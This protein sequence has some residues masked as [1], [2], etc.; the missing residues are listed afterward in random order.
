MEWHRRDLAPEAKSIVVRWAA[1]HGAAPLNRTVLS[2]GTDAGEVYFDTTV[3]GAGLYDIY[4]LPFVTN[5]AAY[6]RKDAYLPMDRGPPAPVRRCNATAAAAA[7]AAV[8]VVSFEAQS[9]FDLFTRM[10]VAASAPELA[11]MHAALLPSG[12]P[13]ALFPTARDDVIRSSPALPASSSFARARVYYRLQ[14]STRRRPALP[15][16]W[17]LMISAV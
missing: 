9:S 2:A 16:P 11:A 5:G 14:V 13:F 3:H 17:R 1:D 10:E 12:A 15:H 8:A 7:A 6:G 4:Y